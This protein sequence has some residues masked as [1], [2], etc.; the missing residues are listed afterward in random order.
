[1]ARSVSRGSFQNGGRSRD[2]MRGFVIAAALLFGGCVFGSERP[3]FSPSE[4]A[5]PFADGAVVEAIENGRNDIERF[6]FRRT[7]AG[8]AVS[9]AGKE[10]EMTGVLFIPVRRTPEED[11]ILQAPMEG[12]EGD[13]VYGFLW[14]SG[15]GYRLVIDPREFDADARA[16]AW[17]AANCRQRPYGECQLTRAAQ[18]RE[19]AQR[20][21]RVFVTN[22]RTPDDFMTLRIV[23]GSGASR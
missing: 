3:L 4:S 18:L 1:M 17:F 20:H 7:R 15:E 10:E 22:E 5:F 6:T 12:R 23:E 8:Y 14:R 11:Y 16:Q 9:M 19:F 2:F 21:A 13:A